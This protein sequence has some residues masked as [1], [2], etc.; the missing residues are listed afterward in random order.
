[1]PAGDTLQTVRPSD[2]DTPVPAA[3]PRR[4][5]LLVEAVWAL[6]AALLSIGAAISVQ[7]LYDADLNVPLGNAGDSLFSQML[8]RTIV[9]NHWLGVNHAIGA[10]FGSSLYDS[11]VAYGDTT[12]LLY[13]K[14]L[15]LFTQNTAALLNLAYLLGFG[16]VAITAYAALRGLR[17]ERAVSLACAV[18]YATL[19]Y[20]FQRSTGHLMLGLYYAVPVAGYLI[21]GALGHARLFAARADG[22]GR[23]RRW[24]TGRTAVTLLA[25][26]VA[27]TSES[28]YA[29]FALV[30]LVTLATVS[31]IAR[32]SWRAL[33][34]PGAVVAAI[35]ASMLLVQVPQMVWH[36]SH[37]ANVGVTARSPSESE[38]YAFRLMNLIVPAPSHRLTQVGEIGKRYYSITTPQAEAN[39]AALGTVQSIGL[40]I[41]IL[42]AAASAMG[43]LALTRRAALAR[44][45]GAAALVAFIVG[46]LGGGSAVIA[47]FFTPQI[48]AWNRISVYVAFFALVGVALA[49]TWL[50]G[51]IR[52]ERRPSWWRAAQRPALVSGLLVAAITWFGV[53]DQ[54]S[55]AL[56]LGYDATAQQWT[57]DARFFHQVEASLPPD[58]KVL[59]LPYVPFPENPPVFKMR[60]YDHLRAYLH[61]KTLR[62]SYAAIKGRL[63]EDWG[64]GVN[65]TSG[66]QLARQAA[67][68]GFNGIYVDTYGFGDGGVAI[69]ASLEKEL[70]RAPDLISEDGRMV[71]FNLVDYGKQQRAERTP[72]QL[73]VSRDQLLR[74]IT[75]EFG[76]GFQPEEQAGTAKFRWAAARGGIV[77]DNRTNVGRRAKVSFL[78]YTPGDRATKTVLSLGTNAFK[79]V[80]HE[81]GASTKVAFDVDLPPGASVMYLDTNAPDYAPDPRDLRLQ[82]RNFR[83]R[84]PAS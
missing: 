24:M 43:R 61:T 9:D 77:L 22:T 69:L 67:A 72:Q 51:W 80:T 25:C 37:G 30:L 15:S 31:A 78:L 16:L 17:F 58:S 10:P 70:G 46:T 4:R 59:Q 53:W 81:P 39:M 76:G 84:V 57:S 12:Q 50:L 11:V 8:I 3:Q 14:A 63:P 38:T 32:G 26:L 74:P 79:T 48:R 1:M 23:I 52:D 71:F 83:V 45:A 56:V 29:V 62:W 40:L 75:V 6:A 42:A 60:D 66:A 19:T 5:R 44:D 20:H 34:T 21:L 36:H 35:L 73:A 55:P 18:I 47:Y 13:I 27:G 28:Y 41:V 64:R 65:S 82:V 7:H 68:A 54:T 49:L 33:V 2:V